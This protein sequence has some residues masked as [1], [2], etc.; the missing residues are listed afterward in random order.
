[1]A[2]CWLLRTPLE[3]LYFNSSWALVRRHPPLLRDEE[4]ATHFG[5]P[6]STRLISEWW[7]SRGA[8]LWNVANP[9]NGLA[10]MKARRE[11]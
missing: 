1:M 11:Y 7:L 9:A 2:A 3:G 6:I 8:V 4:Q 5:L 10:W